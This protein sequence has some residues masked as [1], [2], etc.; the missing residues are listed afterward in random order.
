MKS[1]YK[2]LIF[3]ILMHV[4]ATQPVSAQ[5]VYVSGYTPSQNNQLFGVYNFL[6]CEF[7]PQLSVPTSF[8]DGNSGSDVIALPNGNVVTLGQRIYVFDPPNPNPV[9]TYIPPVASVFGGATYAPNGTIYIITMASPNSTTSISIFN[10][11]TYAL[12]LVGSLPGTWT[13]FSPFFYNGQLYARAINYN[14]SP[15]YERELVTLSLTNPVVPTVIYSPIPNCS[16]N[17]DAINSGPYAGVYTAQLTTGCSSFDA[18]NTYDVPNNTV[19]PIC[20]LPPE[21]LLTSAGMSEMP[22]GFPTSGCICL[23]DAGNVPTPNASRC[24][25][26]SFTFSSNNEYLEPNDLISYILFSNPADTAGSIVAINNIP[27]FTFNPGTM[28]TGVTYYAGAM[29]GNNLNGAVNL[30]DP[31]LDFSNAMQLIWRPLP[32]VSF[33]TT[34]S[35]VC[36]NAC[37]TIQATFTGT[38]PFTFTYSVT[39]DSGATVTFS[40]TVNSATASFEICPPAGYFGALNIQATDLT[41]AWCS[42]Q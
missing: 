25:N 29:A 28:Q 35:S 17:M 41:D 36:D 37:K 7:C 8:F 14:G 24:V 39:D 10:P 33:T 26:E 18:F 40:Q 23:T 15:P 22:P 27:E 9:Y 6:T 11:V 42:C 1:H 3:I 20:T 16:G 21:L 2:C 13:A 19:T 34:N 4:C 32:T 12:T 38:A 30:N 31:C 5:V